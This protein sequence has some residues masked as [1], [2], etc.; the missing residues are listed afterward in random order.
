MPGDVEITGNDI[1]GGWT[2]PDI[3]LRFRGQNGGVVTAHNVYDN[4]L[5]DGAGLGVDTIVNDSNSAA[6]SAILNRGGNRRY[7]GGSLD[8]APEPPPESPVAKAA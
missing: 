3:I 1:R 6:I 5:R 4:S 7:R 2:G 8:P